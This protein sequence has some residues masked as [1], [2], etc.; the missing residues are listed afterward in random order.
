MAEGENV[1]QT[2]DTQT[3]DQQ[4]QA[5]GWLPEDLAENPSLKKFQSAGD[6]AKSYLEIENFR[7]NS[8]R[9]PGE[10][11]GEEQRQEFLQKVIDKV[12]GLM[13]VPN[14]DDPEAVAQI[15]RQLGAPKDAEG[16]TVPEVDSKG[17]QVDMS[18]AEVFK[19]VAAKHGLSQ[20]QFQ[21]I[22]K[23]ITE[24]N[25]NSALQ[26]QQE[27]DAENLKLAGEWG[28]A[29]E[30]RMKQIANFAEKTEAPP[31]LI[32]ALSLGKVHANTARWLYGLLNQFAG[33]GAAEF[34]VP[35]QDKVMAPAEAKAQIDE[36]FGNKDHPYWKPE[37]PGH[38]EAQEK[39]RQLYKLV[40][41][42]PKKIDLGVGTVGVG[43]GLEFN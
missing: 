21:G 37:A 14:T 12:P 8:I 35:A 36:I 19:G 41:T 1:N 20:D 27:I 34:N 18:V 23:D 7:G 42:N 31:E 16:Y 39:M 4:Q 3:A 43:G 28:H 29:H 32:Q 30:Q 10:D 9:I 33:E 40:E 5:E 22:V 26:T 38:K 13:P 25:V 2:T 15:R 6:L 17:I 24:N 11:A